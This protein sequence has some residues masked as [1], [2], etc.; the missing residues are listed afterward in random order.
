M[1]LALSWL[2]VL[3]VAGGSVEARDCRRAISLAPLVGV[4]LGCFALGVLA[5]LHQLG[6]P[7][8][9]AG[10]LTVGALA[11]ATRGMHVDGLA[12]TADGLGCYGPP[13][14][15]LEVMR[16]GGVGPF[17]A[18][19]LLVVY[20]TQAA[21]FAS[22][23]HSGRWWVVP[24][25][26]ATGRAAL[27][28]CCRRGVPSARAEGL[29]ALVAGSQPLPVPLGWTALL[30]GAAVLTIPE[31]P[32]LGPLAVVLATALVVAV[33]PHIRKRFGGITGDVL[34]AAVELATTVTLVVCVSATA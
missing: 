29:G 34:G 26:V 22:V 8:L 15:A 20:G 25:A 33:L 30:A 3:P 27:G 16:D 7:A 1:R 19:T 9:V 4:L 13:A 6:A 32:W 5:G 31:L 28:W 11:L 18:V 23:L 24:L 17:G 10:I 21:C 12:D 14:R 2:T